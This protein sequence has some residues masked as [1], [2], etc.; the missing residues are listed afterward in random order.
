MEVD[1]KDVCHSERSTH[2]S[3]HTKID[4]IYCCHAFEFNGIGWSGRCAHILSIYSWVPHERLI[5]KITTNLLKTINIKTPMVT[6][7]SICIYSNKWFHTRSK[8]QREPNRG[9]KSERQNW[10]PLIFIMNSF[11]AFA[12]YWK[13]DRFFVRLVRRGIA[14]V[15]ARA[16]FNRACDNCV[17]TDMHLLNWNYIFFLHFNSFHLKFSTLMHSRSA[18]G[19]FLSLLSLLMALKWGP[20]NE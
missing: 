3:T 4:L 18:L 6:V 5:M 13:C 15:C 11:T 17:T 10:T 8:S 7:L 1:K 14:C 16:I 19:F 2:T 20:N 12:A 9:R